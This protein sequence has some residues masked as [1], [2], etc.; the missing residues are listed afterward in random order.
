MCGDFTALTPDVIL[1]AV[2]QALNVRLV[3]LAHPHRSYINR[4]YEVQTVD[5]RRF[6]AK[7]YRPGRWT[8]ETLLEEHGFVIDCAAE[9]IP[10]AAPLRLADGGTLSTAEGIWFAVFDKRWGREFEAVCEEDWRRLGRLLGRMHVVGARRTCSHRVVLHPLHSV[11]RDLADLRAGGWV[12]PSECEAF[13]D[14]ASRLLDRITPMFAEVSLQRIHGDCHWQNILERPGEGLM[15]IDFD[16]MVSGPPI[17]D[18]W[19][20][21]PDRLRQSR[22]EIDLILEGYEMFREFDDRTF[23]LIEP[24]RAM[25]MLYFLAWCGRQLADPNYRLKF[26]EWGTAAFWRRQTGDLMRQLELIDA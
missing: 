9:E 2:E 13:F 20:L 5:G 7:F 10:V 11:A 18:L 14:V 16:D 3:G 6:I 17:Q 26:P 24:L 15:L 8:Y 19:M 21:L 22:R 1:D 23:C 12:T 25:R 4:V